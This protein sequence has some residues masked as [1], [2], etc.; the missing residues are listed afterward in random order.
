MLIRFLI[1]VLILLYG[2]NINTPFRASRTSPTPFPVAL[3]KYTSCHV[4]RT[5]HFPHGLPAIK[6]NHK[7]TNI[8]FR[9]FLKK[10]KKI[11]IPDVRT[12]PQWRTSAR[13]SREGSHVLTGRPRPPLRATMAPFLDRLPENLCEGRRKVR[14]W[15]WSLYL[16]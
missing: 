4:I 2:P 6:K 8:Q 15:R 10:I 7:F 16:N 5:S 9:V 14:R 11:K 3:P 12:L 13:P 1:D